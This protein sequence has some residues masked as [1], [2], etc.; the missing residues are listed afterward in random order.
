MRRWTLVTGGAGYVGSLLVPML[1]SQGRNVRVLDSLK[2]GNGSSLL[3]VWS[4]DRF[5]FVR[6]ARQTRKSDALLLAAHS[7]R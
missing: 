7:R 6:R 3:G 2:H 5:E 4:D 1:L